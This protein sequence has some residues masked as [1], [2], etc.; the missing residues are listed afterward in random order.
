MPS[1]RETALSALY[2]RLQ[3][4]SG[5]LVQRNE[6]YPERIPSGGIISL[7]DGEPGEP[8]VTLSPLTYHYQHQAEVICAVQRVR[9]ADRDALLDDLLRQV[10]NAITSD[11]MD[12][13]LGGAVEYV[14]MQ[15]P[16]TEGV[17]TEG[18]EGL[19]VAVMPVILFFSTNSPVS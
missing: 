8:E 9:S 4:I 14:E 15:A 11:G 5:S 19:K 3:T 17:S 12:T 7:E 18:A 13:T 10:G 1:V 16:V 6:M 2:E